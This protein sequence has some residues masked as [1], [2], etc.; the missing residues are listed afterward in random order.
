MKSLV[1]IHAPSLETS[2]NKS[3]RNKFACPMTFPHIDNIGVATLCPIST[4]IQ[5]ISL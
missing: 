4:S 2:K 1:G 5:S 3:H